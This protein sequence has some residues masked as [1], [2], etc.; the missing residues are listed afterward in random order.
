MDFNDDYIKSFKTRDDGDDHDSNYHRMN[1][2]NNNNSDSITKKR[3]YTPI[4]YEIDGDE[5]DDM[6]NVDRL[7]SIFN[8]KKMKPLGLE[9]NDDFIVIDGIKGSEL[10]REDGYSLGEDDIVYRKYRPYGKEYL[11]DQETRLRLMANNESYVF[12]CDFA[13]SIRKE[14]REVFD[15]EDYAR[16][17]KQ[18]EEER[19]SMQIEKKRTLVTMQEK[20]DI[21][22]KIEIL[23]ITLNENYT[24]AKKMQPPAYLQSFS[25]SLIGNFP[26]QKVNTKERE[27][28][29]NEG[30]EDI[31]HENE[32]GDTD[33][34][35]LI[36]LID[37][38]NLMIETIGSGG[39]AST[40]IRQLYINRIL[41]MEM[42]NVRLI[43][44]MSLSTSM[45]AKLITFFWYIYYTYL[46]DNDSNIAIKEFID[47]RIR[48]IETAVR[49]MGIDQIDDI[50]RVVKDL[51]R[52][53]S[54]SSSS[55]IDWSIYRHTETIDM[56]IFNINKIPFDYISEILRLHKSLKY[57]SPLWQVLVDY[58]FP[59]DINKVTSI[60]F[61]LSLFG[62]AIFIDLL[63]I[64]N[65]DITKIPLS[66]SMEIIRS[67][68]LWIYFDENNYHTITTIFFKDESMRKPLAQNII[69]QLSLINKT[70]LV[71]LNQVY[72]II[73]SAYINALLNFFKETK[74]LSG[75]SQSLLISGLVP[76]EGNDI[77]KADK[78]YAKFK[79]ISKLVNDDLF[80]EFILKGVHPLISNS[81]NTINDPI[82]SSKDYLSYLTE[83]V[84]E[85]HPSLSLHILFQYYDVF[86]NQYIEFL[87]RQKTA[88]QRALDKARTKITSMAGDES[89]EKNPMRG[90][91]PYTQRRSFT[92]DPINSGFI[93]IKQE[94]KT[95][96]SI[97][98]ATV[99]KYCPSLRGLP[100]SGFHCKSARSTNLT[101]F[102]IDFLSALYAKR[103]IHFPDKYHTLHHQ[104]AIKLSQ[105]D[106]IR[107][108]TDY[109]YTQHGNS[110]RIMCSYLDDNGNNSNSNSRN[111]ITGI[112][113]NNNMDDINIAM[114]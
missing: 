54:P 55:T 91:P 71:D 79:T 60:D 20:Y 78:Y 90:N 38:I 112:Y 14:P 22:K 28:L 5:D 94:I 25:K 16:V 15:Q 61:S 30:L 95:L 29:K 46:L 58:A 24:R 27:M 75:D 86:Q 42:N 97:G 113:V 84:P 12:L 63:E 82:E 47:S 18:R 83:S 80:L 72:R 37:R 101:A 32:I 66:T 56:S 51:K 88:T 49:D 76:I 107:P 31:E 59:V 41:E 110:Y 89:I 7:A 21:I 4:K 111:V 93:K 43:E 48:Y 3:V 57:E 62:D 52:Y 100:L 109:S 104:N 106:T 87:S 96:F 19:L 17:Q 36:G 67:H 2:N 26:S 8:T 9:V 6:K 102:F 64:M 53:E 70:Y 99:H 85:K 35:S 77:E 68:L 1:N 81:T 10:P 98:L 105:F 65:D 39:S 50:I 44:S 45:S 103:E 23:Q 13:G 69:N 33:Y 114:F 108:L 40:N 73:I 92:T 34:L 11:D 74:S